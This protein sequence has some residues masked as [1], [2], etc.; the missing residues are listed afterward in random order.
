MQSHTRRAAVPLATAGI[1][2]GGD[3]LVAACNCKPLPVDELLRCT[4]IYLRRR[5]E[6]AAPSSPARLSDRPR[7][8]PGM[9]SSVCCC[10]AA[11]AA[12]VAAVL[13]TVV[14]RLSVV[15]L[16]VVCQEAAAVEH[17]ASWL[18]VVGPRRRLYSAYRFSMDA[19]MRRAF[20]VSSRRGLRPCICRKLRSQ[21]CKRHG[22]CE[23]MAKD[24]PTLR[25]DT[26]FDTPT[27]W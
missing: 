9:P 15:W 7:C 25:P 26:H 18:P 20:C 2:E 5:L 1:G 17:T 4:V 21:D 24:T 19:G 8:C 22:L 23:S 3:L 11:G 10:D 12:I 13:A 16:P 27:Q 6:R 14:V